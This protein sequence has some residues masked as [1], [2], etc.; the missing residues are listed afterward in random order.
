MNKILKK[1]LYIYKTVAY[2]IVY[3]FLLFIFQ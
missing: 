3:N 1:K 2:N